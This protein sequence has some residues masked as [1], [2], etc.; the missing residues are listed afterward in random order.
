MGPGVLAMGGTGRGGGAGV[1]HEA[2]DTGRRLSG[3][4]PHPWKP[5]Q[6]HQWVSLY[7]LTG[8]N[9]GTRPPQAGAPCGLHALL[10]HTA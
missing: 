4:F 1:E 9:L 5:W 7:S 10:P 3:R 2:Q 6:V 8:L